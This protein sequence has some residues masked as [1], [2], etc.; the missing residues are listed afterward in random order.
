MDLNDF[1]N[2][3][4]KLTSCQIKDCKKCAFINRTRWREEDISKESPYIASF[5]VNKLEDTG[6]I[7][8]RWLG[9]RPHNLG[10]FNVAYQA[11]ELALLELKK[12]GGNK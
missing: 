11:C 10:I 12:K 8:K 3:Y 9:E 2:N 1:I 7:E 4:K 5:I 6:F